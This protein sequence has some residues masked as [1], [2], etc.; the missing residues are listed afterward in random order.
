MK[1]D[2]IGGSARRKYPWVKLSTSKEQKL[3]LMAMKGT[4]I[5]LIDIRGAL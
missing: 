5:A 3:N 2:I 4:S 1:W